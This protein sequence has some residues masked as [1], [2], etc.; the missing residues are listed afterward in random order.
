[1]AFDQTSAPYRKV[2]ACLFGTIGKIVMK[3]AAGIV[4]FQPLP[5]VGEGRRRRQ[6]RSRVRSRRVQGFATASSREVGMG[7]LMRWL[8]SGRTSRL[9][10]WAAVIA[11]WLAL[12]DAAIA[13]NSSNSKEETVV[14]IHVTDFGINQLW[15]PFM[16]PG[17]TGTTYTYLDPAD[18][19]LTRPVLHRG[20]NEKNLD[21]AYPSSDVLHVIEPMHSDADM[22]RYS[23]EYLTDLDASAL[24]RT[25]NGGLDQGNQEFEIQLIEHI[26]LLGYLDAGSRKAS[27]ADVQSSTPRQT[28]VDIF[29]STAYAAIGRIIDQLTAKGFVVNVNFVLGSN[30]TKVFSDSVHS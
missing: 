27:T 1:M 18:Q 21:T 13:R 11:S 14:T 17:W 29:G 22:T 10:C 26:N 20:D 9:F 24:L 7:N 12:P 19:A 6:G 4:I 15:C 23:K 28:R 8:R 3:R 25:I 5:S 2:S 16:Q 30:A